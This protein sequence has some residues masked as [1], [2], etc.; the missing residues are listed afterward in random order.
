MI[1]VGMTRENIMANIIPG[2]MRAIKPKAMSITVII[3]A[4]IK[5]GSL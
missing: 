3:A 4:A 1:M 5:E 2:I